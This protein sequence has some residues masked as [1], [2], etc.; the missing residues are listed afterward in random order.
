MPSQ[1]PRKPFP[2]WRLINGVK[3]ASDGELEV[4]G[5]S[6]EF[7]SW[8][9]GGVVVGGLIAEIALAW[10]HPPYDSFWERWGSV[11]ANAL[12]TIGVAGEVLFSRMAFRRDKEL[13]LRSDKKFAEAN[14]RADEARRAARKAQQETELLRERLAWRR[15]TKRQFDSII[16]SMRE[17][18]S[19]DIALRHVGNDHESATFA[20]EIAMALAA[21][22]SRVTPDWMTPDAQ[23][24]L[25]LSP[26]REGDGSRFALLKSALEN[27]GLEVV[28]GNPLDRL[29]LHIGS[30]PPLV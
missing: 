16:I 30:K 25:S 17:F 8:R 21:T 3:N 7:W 19:F 20:G 15:L 2:A 26:M 22:G 5:D 6:C 18:P 9:C 24:G 23:F 10:C 1:N 28:I 4:S 14:A 11:L 12:V 13:K 29:T 27:A